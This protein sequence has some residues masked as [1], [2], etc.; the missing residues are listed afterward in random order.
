MGTNYYAILEETETTCPHCERPGYL[1]AVRWHIGKSSFG[2]CF[3]LHVGSRE[4]PHIPKSLDEWREVWK[5]AVR[6]EDEYG[7]GVTTA[8]MERIILDRDAF[9]IKNPSRADYDWFR[10]NM[11]EP[12]PH[13]LARHSIKADRYCV[14]H[15]DGTYDLLVG[16]FS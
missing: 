12:G 13:L 4:E 7:R 9:G 11:A 16:T 2:W 6:I 10:L 14:G 15:G 8:E 3:A 1:Q 5:K